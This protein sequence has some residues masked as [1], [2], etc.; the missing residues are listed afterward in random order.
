MYF[1]MLQSISVIII[2]AILIHGYVYLYK[3]HTNYISLFTG[4]LISLEIR[5]LFIELQL[6]HIDYSYINDFIKN[7]PLT[8]EVIDAHIKVL[9]QIAD[10]YQIQKN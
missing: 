5:I 9:D 4:K 7:S 1:D 6:G 3:S 2:L 8:K 10:H